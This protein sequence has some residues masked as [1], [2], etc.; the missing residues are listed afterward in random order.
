MEELNCIKEL[1]EH[2]KDLEPCEEC[3]D[4]FPT[5]EL[6]YIN[7]KLYCIDCSCRCIECNQMINEDFGF[8]SSFCSKDCKDQYFYDLEE[9]DYKQ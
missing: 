2:L 8:N 1:E 9:D 4:L 6:N 3:Y 7:D 5:E